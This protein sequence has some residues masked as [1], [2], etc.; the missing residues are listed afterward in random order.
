MEKEKRIEE[1]RIKEAF[2]RKQ[3]GLE[4]SEKI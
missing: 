1:Q 2:L 4:K 3:K